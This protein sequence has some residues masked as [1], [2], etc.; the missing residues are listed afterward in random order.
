MGKCINCGRET[1][2]SYVYY[3]G[4]YHSTGPTSCDAA[5]KYNAV[6]YTNICM[7]SEFLCPKCTN[8]GSGE[9][10]ILAGLCFL[11]GAYGIVAPLFAP[12]KEPAPFWIIVGSFAAAVLF[13]V[14]GMLGKRMT[15]RDIR[16]D[17]GIKSDAGSSRLVNIV[18]YKNPAKTYFTTE[19]YRNMSKY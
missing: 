14:L 19:Q 16:E 10:Y 11:P 17:K 15:D 6:K 18:K 1:A 9:L 2:V 12:D 13:V 7:H 5:W 3:S 4:D 8:G